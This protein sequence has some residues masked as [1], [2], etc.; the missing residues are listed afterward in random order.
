MRSPL[1]GFMTEEQIISPEMRIIQA[2]IECIERYGLQGA[3]NR[4]IA[5][6]AD[7]NVAAIN[8]YFR[9]KQ[10]L[11]DRVMDITLDNAFDW[12]D[13]L[14]LPGDT[15]QEWCVE[16]LLHLMIGARNYPGITRA[17]F[18]DIILDGDYHSLAARRMSAFMAQWARELKNRGLKMPEA[19]LQTAVAELGFA[20]ISAAMAPRFFEEPFG[21]SLTTED[22]MRAFYTDLVTKVLG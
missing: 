12:N 4:R 10:N 22:T 9:S 16:I 7:V 5:E 8:Y 20:F 11:I 21:M 13:L 1:A 18:Q 15:P 19:E 6:V 17:H 14:P 3:T 2:T